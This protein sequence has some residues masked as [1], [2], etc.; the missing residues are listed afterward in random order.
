VIV[1]LTPERMDLAW[2]WAHRETLRAWNTG[3]RHR[4]PEKSPTTFEDDRE[5]RFQA[6]CAENGVAD[7]LRLPWRTPREQNG[8]TSPD[9]G[10]NVGVRW[11]R[12]AGPHLLVRPGDPD[13][14]VFFLVSGKAPE[15]TI[16]G[17][18]L[19]SRAKCHEYLRTDWGDPPVW[20]VPIADLVVP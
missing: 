12:Y 5:Q 11:S 14:F 1:H 18:V 8:S 4:V 2:T 13:R 20:A 17:S 19:A 7:H 16:H 10:H 3:A 15:M 9:V 6:Y